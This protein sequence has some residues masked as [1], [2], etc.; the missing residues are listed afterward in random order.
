VQSQVLLQCER[1]SGRPA[2]RSAGTSSFPHPRHSGTHDAPADEPGRQT[3]IRLDQASAPPQR[4][5][6]GCAIQPGCQFCGTPRYSGTRPS[7]MAADPA[8]WDSLNMGC[9]RLRHSGARTCPVPA[10]SFQWPS[11]KPM[12]TPRISESALPQP[13]R[14][15]GNRGYEHSAVLDGALN[16]RVG[17]F[18]E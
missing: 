17:V 15:V 8:Y 1:E 13:V 4:R 16:E 7:D 11:N 9:P 5:H 2:G 6:T 14:L 10:G 18:D 3:T 12:M